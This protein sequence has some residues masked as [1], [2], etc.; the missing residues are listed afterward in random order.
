MPTKAQIHAQDLYANLLAE[1]N[2]RVAAINHCTTGASG[3]APPFV[4]DFCYLQ[5]RMICELVALGCL[6]AHGDI[7]ET[8]SKTLQKQWSAD[9]IME[10]LEVLHPHFYPQAIKST[11]TT[12]PDGKKNH[13]LQAAPTSPLSRDEFLKLYHGCGEM[14]H[15]GNVRKLLKGQF[16]IQINY[17]E[18]TAKTQKI[19]DLL[20]HHILVM[21]GGEQ[22]FLAM[23]TNADIGRPQ[24]AI[25]ETPPG[26]PMDYQSPSFLKDPPK[27]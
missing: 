11:V 24:V 5:I 1:I 17:P 26:Q 22:A 20:S 16:P 25:A 23:L 27:E 9:K 8:A 14:L 15:R 12:L 2:F 19:I 21:R 7:K 6:V 10:A 3:L 18:I 13:H 4:K